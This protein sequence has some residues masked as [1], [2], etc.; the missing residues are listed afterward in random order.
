[1]KLVH[2]MT[3]QE[4]HLMSERHGDMIDTTQKSL[5]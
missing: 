5:L 3:T 1:M 2:I 4:N